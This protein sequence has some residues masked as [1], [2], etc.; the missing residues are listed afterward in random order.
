MNMRRNIT[1]GLL[2]A[3]TGALS[4]P[5][6]QAQPAEFPPRQITIVVPFPAGG[7]TDQLARGIAQKMVDN[8]KVPVIV[9]N[10]PGGSAQIAANAVKQA[11]A[12]GA[13]IF[14]GD[15]GAFA[16]NQSLYAKLSY[17]ITKDF[18]PLAR[19]ALAPSLLLVPTNSPFNSVADFVTSARLK[20]VNIASQT[21]GSGGH[22][23]AELLKNQSQLKLN[24]I[25]YRGSAPALTDLIGGQVEILFDPIISSGPF[26]KDGRLKALAIGAEQRSPQFP[27]VPT[28]KE[29]GL[30]SANL[31]AWFAMAV[32][33]GT[34]R[35]VVTRLSD[36]VVK[37]IR[38]PE[39]AKRFADQGLEVA[40]LNSAEF[41]PFLEAEVSKWGK[42]IRDAGIKLE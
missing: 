36:E 20:P 5:M 35:P 8:L 19:L 11:P 10:K 30:G 1:K 15:I 41:Q 17:D 26:V 14:I 13:T 39:V 22:L 12:D 33:A 31:V 21:T 38:A 42:V 24:H 25:P 7:V 23:F 4:L 37:A 18:V 27:Q 28:L 6:A 40:P 16:L 9:D 29:T 34:P 2:L 3:A 32:K